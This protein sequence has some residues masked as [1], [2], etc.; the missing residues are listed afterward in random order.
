MCSH[1]L[2]VLMEEHFMI[3]IVSLFHS[4][5]SVD[6]SVYLCSSDSSG[7]TY[8]GRCGSILFTSLVQ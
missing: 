4:V 2:D 1:R 6:T 8:V 3:Y 5:F 7:D